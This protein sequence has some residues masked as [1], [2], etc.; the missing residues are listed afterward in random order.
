MTTTPE[1][2][3]ELA[4]ELAKARSILENAKSDLASADQ[5]VKDCAAAEKAAYKAFNEAMDAMR[6]KRPRQAKVAT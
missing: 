6:P 3:A 2:A 4:A 1:T 5:H